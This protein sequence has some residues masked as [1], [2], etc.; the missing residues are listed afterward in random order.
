M[1]RIWSRDRLEL[2]GDGTFVTQCVAGAS[3]CVANS[4]TTL[5]VGCKQYRDSFITKYGLGERALSWSAGGWALPR[6]G[7]QRAGYRGSSLM[8]N[9]APLGPYS[10]TMPRAL[11]KP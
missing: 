4:T 2:T 1:V 5:F 6:D 11:W 8:R 7:I 9:S 3:D 10:R